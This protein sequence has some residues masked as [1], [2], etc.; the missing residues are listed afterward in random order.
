MS[1]KTEVGTALPGR[2]LWICIMS[3]SDI[4][5]EDLATG[6]ERFGSEQPMRIIG[7]GISMDRILYSTWDV[8][9]GGQG[10]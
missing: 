7:V 5:Y 6:Y 4:E 9:A 8:C 2:P 1:Y 3:L 10:V